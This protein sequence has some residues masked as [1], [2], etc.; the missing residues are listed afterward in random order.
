MIPCA[1]EG[2]EALAKALTERGARVEA[3]PAYQTLMDGAG[4]D[5]VRERLEDGTID[6]VTF[7]SSST[8]KNFTAALG[9]HA[10]PATVLVACIG[11]STAKTAT[12]RLG[13]A[14]DI[15]ASEHTVGGLLDALERHFSLLAPP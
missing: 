1:L 4:A 6:V 14:P 12:E 9:T 7:T 2:D 15:V 10:L 5:G 11:P 13:R 8:V 3:V